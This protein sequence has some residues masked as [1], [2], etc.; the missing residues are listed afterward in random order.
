MRKS[1]TDFRGRKLVVMRKEKPGKAVTIRGFVSADEWDGRKNVIA[2]SITTD[3][4]DYRVELDKV[5][6][7]LFDYLDEDVE[8]TGTIRQEK[9]GTKY[10]RVSNYEVLEEEYESEQGFLDDEDDFDFDDDEDDD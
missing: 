4:E 8:V 7:E 6:E 9:N 10:I 5:G 3:D 1:Q 2:I